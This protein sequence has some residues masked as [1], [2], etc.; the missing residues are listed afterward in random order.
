MPCESKH[1]TQQRARQRVKEVFEAEEG[2]E[3]KAEADVIAKRLAERKAA[4]GIKSQDV[5]LSVLAIWRKGLGARPSEGQ[6]RK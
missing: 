4:K 3:D 5:T 6:G 2:L 1:S